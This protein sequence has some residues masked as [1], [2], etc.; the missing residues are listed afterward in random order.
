MKSRVSLT[1]LKFFRQAALSMSFKEAAEQLYVTQA[2]VSQQIKSLEQSMGVKLFNRHN[3]EISLTIEGQQLLPYV[4]RGFDAF[5]EGLASLGDDP[6]PD[7]I[8]LTSLP[9]FASR[10]LIPKVANF[11][12]IHPDISLRISPSLRLEPFVNGQLDLAVRY[13]RGNYEGLYSRFLCH[14]YLLPV[15]H[16]ELVDLTQPIVPQLRDIAL[17]TDDGVDVEEAW[18]PFLK[19]LGIPSHRK[20]SKLHVGDSNM[21]IE[22]IL[23][24]QGMSLL[25]FSLIYELLKNHQL[26]CPLPFYFQT[27]YSY[28]LVGPQRH[29]QY[30]KIQAFEQWLIQ[31][32]KVIETHWQD[33]SQDNLKEVKINVTG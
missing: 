20:I 19:E 8:N 25:R 11:Q 14:D 27:G 21:L 4:C 24:R 13:G 23:C 32:M 17:L 10:W 3:R 26:I 1:A 22:P 30:P 33:Y 28:Y 29:F 12:A 9:S 7:L 5:D 6:N 16:P 18:K 31:E 15:C 2:A